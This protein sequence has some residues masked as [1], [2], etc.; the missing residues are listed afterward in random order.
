MNRF[1]RMKII[2]KNDYIRIPI[3]SEFTSITNE[4]YGTKVFKYNKTSPYLLIMMINPDTNRATIEFTGKILLDNYPKLIS[5]ET[6][7]ECFTRINDIGV[8]KLDV[9][10]IIHDSTVCKL[11]VTVDV[12]IPMNESLKTLLSMAIIDQKKWQGKIRKKNGIDIKK[13]VKSNSV[14]KERISFY[15]KS[16]ELRRSKNRPFIQALKNPQLMFD[17]FEGK[18][19]IE[20]NLTSG[21][22]IRKVLEIES[23][24]LLNVLNTKT[25]VLQ[26]ICNTILDRAL[27]ANLKEG[28]LGFLLFDNIQDYYQNLLLEKYYDDENAI[29]P[30]FRY[31]YS[32]KSNFRRKRIRLRKVK[33]IRLNSSVNITN[34]IHLFDDLLEKIQNAA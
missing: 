9:D 31:F 12:N 30:V 19:R 8:C 24:E 34:Q 22:M 21:V 6:I 28:N 29:E 1:D 16:D 11:D 5:M 26:K 15:H 13:D 14:L 23:L 20:Y 2:T 25:L 33:N 3:D 27:I 32:A 18:T 7:G 17:Y 10:S 4:K